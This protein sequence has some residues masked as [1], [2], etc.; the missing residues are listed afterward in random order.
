[1]L[2]LKAKNVEKEEISVAGNRLTPLLLE[3]MNEEERS[4]E[5]EGPPVE[6]PTYK[7]IMKARKTKKHAKLQ[8]LL[9]EGRQEDNVVKEPAPEISSIAYKS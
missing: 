9:G 4:L 5:E 2:E 3:P 1:M 8:Q 6:G 7:E